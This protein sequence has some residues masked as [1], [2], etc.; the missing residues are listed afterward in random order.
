[1]NT[2]SA[3]SIPRQRS[4]IFYCQSFP[5]GFHCKLPNQRD[6]NILFRVCLFQD[7]FLFWLYDLYLLPMDGYLY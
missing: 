3:W 2:Q 7:S 4:K 6:I 5:L 1:M